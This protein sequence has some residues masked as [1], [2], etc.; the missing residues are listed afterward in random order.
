MVP[1]YA[2]GIPT[3]A[4]AQYSMVLCAMCWRAAKH[5]NSYL[6]FEAAKVVADFQMLHG[7]DSDKGWLIHGGDTNHLLVGMILQV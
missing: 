7:A 6:G 1:P 3:T 4:A 2:V 5:L